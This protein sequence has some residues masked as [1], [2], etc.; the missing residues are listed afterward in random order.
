[1]GLHLAERP[2][3]ESVVQADEAVA[4]HPLLARRRSSRALGGEP[5]PDSTVTR[6]L[7][8]ARWAPSSGNRQPWSFIVVPRE[9]AVAHAR[10]TELLTGRNGWWAPKAPLLVVALA[11]THNP[12]GG[13]H[14][15]ALYDL[16]LAM[17]QLAVQATAEGLATHPMGGFD[18][19]RAREVLEIPEGWEPVVVM[20]IGHVGP[21]EG[22]H[23]MLRATETA[24]RSRRPLEEIAFDGRFGRPR[25]RTDG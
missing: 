16:G 12:D 20:A 11:R 23:E 6:L 22:V 7:E 4:L 5:L 21:P 15:I 24:R 19:G 9:D 10:V 14:P 1:V 2:A 18:K 8:A 17:G 13:A 3:L 25:V